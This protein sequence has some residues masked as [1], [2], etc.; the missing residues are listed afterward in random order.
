MPKTPHS[1]A[2][3]QLIATRDD[4]TR[5]LRELLQPAAAEGRE[6]KPN[7]V[8]GKVMLTAEVADLKRRIALVEQ[9]ERD[10]AAVASAEY[11]DAAAYDSTDVHARAM[12]EAAAFMA[13]IA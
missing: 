11:Q 13:S 12:Q 8:R 6:L 4:R 10:G 1:P 3:A 9:L 5:A 7:E 2:L